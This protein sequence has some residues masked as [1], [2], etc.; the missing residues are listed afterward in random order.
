[1]SYRFNASK[2]LAVINGWPD[3]QASPQLIAWL[4]SIGVKVIE[5]HRHGDRNVD[6]GYNWGVKIAL[7]S[8]FNQFIFAD[9][10]IM[11]GPMTGPWLTDRRDVV[12][13]EYD[14]GVEGSFGDEHSVHA[15]LWR[16]RRRVLEAVGAAPF[17]WQFDLLGLEIEQCPCSVFARKA[18]AA[19]FS[20]GHAGKAFHAPREKSALPMRMRLTNLPD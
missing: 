19:G 14:T 10:D 18:V 7:E 17:A 16:T 5:I 9:N 8:E 11:P 3:L 2:C 6:V 13:V 4:Y 15:A 1:M 12:G 20:V